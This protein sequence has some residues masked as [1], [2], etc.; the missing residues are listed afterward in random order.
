MTHCQLRS[1][2]SP[3]HRN[4]RRLQSHRPLLEPLERRKLLSVVISPGGN[5]ATYTDVDGDHVRI[6][7]SKGKF[8]PAD[9][10]SVPAGVGDEIQEID[11]TTGHFNGANLIVQVKKAASGDGQVNIGY[12]NATGHDLGVV[13]VIPATSAESTPVMGT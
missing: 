7:V 3:Q 12:I 1:K 4:S 10:T 6:T 9:F 8:V 5:A 11:L 13:K 2:G